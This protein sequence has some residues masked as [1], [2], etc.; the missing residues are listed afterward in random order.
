MAQDHDQRGQFTEENTVALKH[1]AGRYETTGELPAEMRGFDA[2]LANELLEHVGGDPAY[3][4][5]AQSAAR[6]ATLLELAY[7][8][9]TRQDVKVMWLEEDEG[10]RKVVNWQPILNRLGSFHEGLRRDL[11]ALGLTPQSRARLSIDGGGGVLDYEAVLREAR[12]DES[13]ED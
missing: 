11:D 2:A 8:W 13:R 4:L 7:S 1:G 3:R 9:L 10:G 6:R 12:M 5:L